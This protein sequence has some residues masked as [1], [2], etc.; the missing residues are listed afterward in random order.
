MGLESEE[1]KAQ[2]KPAK[3]WTTDPESTEFKLYEARAR[4]E[5]VIKL[6]LDQ[7]RR[8][9]QD[10]L[11]AEQEQNESE[12]PEPK[13]MGLIFF[14]VALF[15]SVIGDLIDF[16]TGGTIGWLIGLAI[17]GILALMFGMSSSGRKQFKKMAI[18]F[19]GES[20][21]FVA[22]LPFRTITTIW[23]FVSSHSKIIKKIGDKVEHQIHKTGPA[24]NVIDKVV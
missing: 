17:D 10:Q 15:F 14:L 9:Y 7:E 20:I 18:G 4:G 22:M 3:S 19:V 8:A 13:K 1:K 6:N 21:P 23:S 2:E 16:F 5:D 12:A 11:Q 24:L